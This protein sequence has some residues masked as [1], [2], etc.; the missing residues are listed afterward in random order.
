M[1]KGKIMIHKIFI[2]VIPYIIAFY[3][4]MTCVVVII[5]IY[6]TFRHINC[7][8]CGTKNEGDSNFCKKCGAELRGKKY[9]R[10]CKKN[11]PIDAKFCVHCGEKFTEGNIW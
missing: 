10:K 4:I 7:P 9:C 1:K 3:V 11:N 2:F 6:T 5:D 8:K